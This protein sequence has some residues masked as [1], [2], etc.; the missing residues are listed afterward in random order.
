MEAVAI[1]LSVDA[2]K[3]EDFENGFREAEL[4]V[5]EDFLERGVMLSA[6]LQRM[7]ISTSPVEGA[8][9]YLIVVLFATGEGHHLHDGD[10]RFQAWNEKA[11]QFQIADPMAFA[12]ETIVRVP[13]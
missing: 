10:P 4:P 9:Q 13:K 1:V 8:I 7:D 12:G 5:W 2:T 11:D 6:S 3:T